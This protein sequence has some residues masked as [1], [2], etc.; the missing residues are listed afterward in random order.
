MHA[1]LDNVNHSEYLDYH[2]H[3]KITHKKLVPEI[4]SQICQRF[5]LLLL[6]DLLFNTK[7]STSSNLNYPQPDN[8][9]GSDHC[10]NCKSKINESTELQIKKLIF[11]SLKNRRLIYIFKLFLLA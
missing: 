8:H 5:L 9:H 10:I 3:L 6:P 4:I 1:S 2:Q 7:T 11:K